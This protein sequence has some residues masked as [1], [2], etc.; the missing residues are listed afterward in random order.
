MLW[1]VSLDDFAYGS[2]FRDFAENGVEFEVL[3]GNAGKWPDF[4]EVEMIRNFEFGG[5]RYG[6]RSVN[7]RS[8]TSVGRR[9][10]P[11]GESGPKV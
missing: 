5:G 9:G 1:G 8:T 3:G 11:T 6:V 4:G 2:C 7:S 10:W